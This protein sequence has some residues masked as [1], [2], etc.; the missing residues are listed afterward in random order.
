MLKFFRKYNTII[1]VFGGAFLMVV[2]LV[3]QAITQLGGG[4]PTTAV[5]F[6]AG[7]ERFRLAD[8]QRAQDDLRILGVIGSSGGIGLA[9]PAGLPLSPDD[10]IVHWLLLTLEA[11]RLGFVSGP[12]DGVQYIDDLQRRQDSTIQSPTQRFDAMLIARDELSRSGYSF[13]QIDGALARARGVTRLFNTI[14][15]ALQVSP[16]ETAYFAER[17]AET[18]VGQVSLIP[19][20]AVIDLIADPDEDELVAH[21]E[22]YRDQHAEDNPFAISYRQPAA[23]RVETLT[24]DRSAIRNAITL[25]PVR[26]R[27]FWQRNQERF[28]E[29]FSAAR[30]R[31]ENALRDERANAIMRELESAV[32]SEIVRS[33]RGLT[34]TDGFFE[35]PA[36]WDTR[37]TDLESLARRLEEMLGENAPTDGS[38]ITLD[39]TRNE[40]STMADLRQL[41]P[42]FARTDMTFTGLSFAQVALGVRELNPEIVPPFTAQVGMLMG[43]MTDFNQSL[44]FVRVNA[45]RPEG[46]APSLDAVRERAIEDLRSIRAF[47]L[48]QERI[49]TIR[50]T[51][52][53]AGNIAVL[54]ATYPDA[55]VVP[56]AEFQRATVRNPEDGTPI[57]RLNV[58][59]LRNA[60]IDAVEGWAPTQLPSEVSASERTVVIASP[61]SKAIFAVFITTRYPATMQWVRA[62]DMNLQRNIAVEYGTMNLPEMFTFRAMASRLNY[63]PFMTGREEDSAAETDS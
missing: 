62:N 14:G 6:E 1:L 19:A 10:M 18:V 61:S 45:V 26:V 41:T 20:A 28:G 13:D 58:E 52:A 40:W 35:L 5:H 63:R 36:D 4:S 33:R 49:D 22:R 27:V 42:R 24:I 55:E 21:F 16:W 25:D 31:V 17:N 50:Q 30:S 3:P 8:M 48:L 44:H 32:R 53:D 47:E 57:A 39:A 38:A 11:D 2:F 59:S 54:S 60:V 37:K 51:V 29:D 56:R 12:G 43:P 15:T 9:L 34:E 7:G 46:P 23:V